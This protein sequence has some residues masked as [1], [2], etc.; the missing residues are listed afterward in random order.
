MGGANKSCSSRARFVCEREQAELLS[1]A[2]GEWRQTR[3]WVRVRAGRDVG[4]APLEKTGCCP[5]SCSSTL[6]ARV[7]RSPL[8]PT[9]MLSVSFSI[10]S[11]FMGLPS[12]CERGDAWQVSAAGQRTHSH[13]Q[14]LTPAS[15]AAT[16]TKQQGSTRTV[17]AAVCKHSE[18]TR[19]R[20]ACE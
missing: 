18:T 9:E 10:L 13:T 5:L 7:K 6:A 15:S 3:G 12:S 17:M 4:S 20:S 19:K 11:A 2:S 8:S 16:Q 14:P 1:A